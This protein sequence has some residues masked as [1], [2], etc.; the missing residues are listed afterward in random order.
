MVMRRRARGRRPSGVR[1]SARK[2]TWVIVAIPSTAL[3]PGTSVPFELLTPIRPPSDITQEIYH[4][5]TNPTVIAVQG[6]VTLAVD[7]VADCLTGPAINAGFAWGIYADTD[8]VSVATF[9][10]PF[11]EGNSNRWMMHHT[12][13]LGIPSRLQ[14]GPGQSP[15]TYG[16]TDFSYRRYEFTQ[17]KYKRRLDSQRD[18]LIFAVENPGGAFGSGSI[19][20]QA[21]FRLLLLE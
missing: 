18:S 9:T 8:A 10:R 17:R 12:G 14:C 16:Q 21:Y 3:P 6:H 7:A 20:F 19:G 5:M 2:Y 13:F 15:F 4:N 11:S 1:G